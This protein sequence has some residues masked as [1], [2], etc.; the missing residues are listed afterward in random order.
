MAD[1]STTQ[2]T[3][4]TGIV[5]PAAPTAPV[6]TP[7]QV[8]ANEQAIAQKLGQTYNSASGQF[9]Q[10]QTAAPAVVKPTPAQPVKEQ[11]PAPVAPVVTQPASETTHVSET[12]TGT[13]TT[14]VSAP[15]PD[16]N[17]GK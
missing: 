1:A 10:A 13:T 3:T 12:P 8:T 9:N 7:D 6:A 17:T 16:F 2:S 11:A 15:A 14:K 4:N 5:A